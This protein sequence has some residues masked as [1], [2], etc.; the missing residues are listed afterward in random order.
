ML[1]VR[2][3]PHPKSRRPVVA[4]LLA[5]ACLTLSLS[6]GC[7][8]LTRFRNPAP[9]APVV[10]DS[11]S[12]LDQLIAAVTQ[13]SERVQQLKADVRV[14]APGM[15]S[16]RGDLQIERPRRLRLQAAVLGI[17]DLGFDLGSNEESFWVWQ[18]ASLPDE[19][20]TLFFARHAEFQQS[21]LRE[22]LQLQPLW[23]VDAL[24]LIEFHA[25][26]QH[27]G[28]FPRDD[29]RV[30]IRSYSQSAERPAIR[31]AV[32]DPRRA[33]VIQQSFYDRQGN[34]LAYLNSIE[35]KY[36]AEHQVSLPHRVELHLSGTSAASAQLTVD[37]GKYVINSLL[38]DPQLLWT[39]PNPADVRR[40]DLSSSSPVSEFPE[41]AGTAGE[42][43]SRSW[44][45]PP[46]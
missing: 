39:M 22:N 20:P 24:G 34:R 44:S 15:P 31:I 43:H 12:S 17:S 40:I 38:G 26:D 4:P 9:A 6:S 42:R 41:Q 35:H 29:G 21:A 36:Y 2:Y 1:T 18:K 46:Y 27:Q 3:P 32:V 16:L 28:P 11:T 37:A 7:Q 19:P 13:Q 8:V 14:S 10:L 45:A 33:L 30:E 23:L 25:E 5:C